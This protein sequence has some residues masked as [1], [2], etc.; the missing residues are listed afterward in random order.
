[1]TTGKE[2]GKILIVWKLIVFY[3]TE[4]LQAFSILLYINALKSGN[5]IQGFLT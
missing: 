1:M 5:T 3:A 4:F 2:V